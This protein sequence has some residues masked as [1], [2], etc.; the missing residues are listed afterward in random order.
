[1]TK[2][3]FYYIRNKYDPMN[4]LFHYFN[5]PT[6]LWTVDSWSLLNPILGAIEITMI[7]NMVLE[8][9]NLVHYKFLT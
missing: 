9:K 1:M 3:T 2:S 5:P 4:G 7:T 8:R 6:S